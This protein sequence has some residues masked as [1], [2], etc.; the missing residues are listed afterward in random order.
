MTINSIEKTIKNIVSTQPNR[1]KDTLSE[2]ITG[3]VLSPAGFMTSAIAFIVRRKTWTTYYKM[4]ENG[5][6]SWVELCLQF[7]RM[8]VSENSLSTCNLI[9]DDTTVC[10]SSKKA[11]CVKFHHQHS[12]KVNRPKYLL[13]QCWVSLAITLGTNFSRIATPLMS[14]IMDGTTEGGKI[15]I[16]KNL[17]NRYADDLK[18]RIVNVLVDCWFMKAS[19]INHCL[20]LNM[21]VIGQIRRDSRIYAAPKLTTKKSRGRPKMYGNKICINHIWKRNVTESKMDIYGKTQ[22]LK[23]VSTICQ[24]RFLGS[25]SVRVVWV[26]LKNSHGVWGKTRMLLST[27]ASMSPEKII[28]LYAERWS[29]EPMFNEL[30]NNFGL[31]ETWQQKKEGVLRWFNI[32]SI[33]YA[34]L[35]LKAQEIVTPNMKEYFPWRIDAKLTPGLFQAC[36]RMNK[37]MLAKFMPKTKMHNIHYHEFEQNL[38]DNHPNQFY[39]GL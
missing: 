32:R 22:S 30:K 28:S 27:N 35:M 10:R 21:N 17:L 1:V 5:K 19:F 39:Q 37:L 29:I 31:N 6:M 15:Q 18:G 36:L 20:S 9:I 25:R 24:A 2:I 12:N 33:A 16:A 38:S 23:Y 11:P 26:A 34:L 8:L 14:D 13:G 3:A 4:I 7:F